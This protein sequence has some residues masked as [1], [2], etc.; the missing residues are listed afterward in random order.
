MCMIDVVEFFV[1]WRT[2][3]FCPT[4]QL[5]WS[6]G[7]KVAPSPSA[8]RCEGRGDPP[9]KFRRIPPKIVVLGLCWVQ[10]SPEIRL[11]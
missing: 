3:A 1:E 7:E 2:G 9:Q 6:G 4:P 10:I 11:P 5:G 8:K